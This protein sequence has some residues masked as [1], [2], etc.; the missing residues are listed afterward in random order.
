VVEAVGQT[1]YTRS[2]GRTA[3]A[4]IAEA[5]LLACQD[6]GLDT[7]DIDGIL[8][9]VSTIAPEPIA[10]WFGIGTVQ[11]ARQELSRR[12]GLGPSHRRLSGCHATGVLPPRHRQLESECAPR[13]AVI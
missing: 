1:A 9:S 13:H 10:L 6:A 12:R 4:L 5:I 3:N 11:D 7:S 8:P 2:T